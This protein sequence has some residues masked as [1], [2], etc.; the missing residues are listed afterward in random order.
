MI[1]RL[2]AFFILLSCSTSNS[3]KEKVLDDLKYRPSFQGLLSDTENSTLSMNCHGEP[4]FEKLS[5]RFNS[6]WIVARPSESTLRKWSNSDKKKMMAKFDEVFSSHEQLQRFKQAMEEEYKYLKENQKNEQAS[7]MNVYKKEYSSAY[8]HFYQK[9]INCMKEKTN[10]IKKSCLLEYS[11]KLQ[12]LQ[13]DVCTMKTH[14]SGYFYF[15]KTEPDKWVST[16]EYCGTRTKRILMFTGKEKD[17]FKKYPGN[18]DWTFSEESVE[19]SIDA[20]LKKECEDSPPVV[21][22]LKYEPFAHHY[23]TLKCD[24]I[25]FDK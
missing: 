25:R 23:A 16:F 13:H 22:S 10:K 9:T 21:R 5:C 3:V 19:V 6:A 24:I 18:A 20:Q 4:P 15:N 14:E 17:W 2:L 1:F 8:D 7:E 12:R 11:L